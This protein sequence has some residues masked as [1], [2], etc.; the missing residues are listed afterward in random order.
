MASA[1]YT[2]TKLDNSEVVFALV[3]STPTGAEYRVSSRS[4]GLPLFLKIATKI[5]N[6][7]SKGND[8]VI[9]TIGDV[10]QNSTTG[11][12]STGSVVMDVSVPRDGEW[13]DTMTQDLLAYLQAFITDARI[14]NLSDAV[15]P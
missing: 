7:G 5:G 9:V 12:I 8:H 11:A 3:G 2:L 13:T 6:P 4:L 14:A 1:S 15:V 10:V